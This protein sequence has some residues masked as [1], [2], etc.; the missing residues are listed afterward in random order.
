MEREILFRAKRLDNGQWV[1]GNVQ[2]PNKE[3]LHVFNKWFMWDE[4]NIQRQV[5][6]GTVGQF[7]GMT[8]KHGKRIFEG[9]IIR[10]GEIPDKQSEKISSILF[11]HDIL[12]AI[13][14][15]IW[16]E[17]VGNIYDNPELS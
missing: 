4:K 6:S 17:I 5:D 15:N 14:R 2:V 12:Y 1:E 10:I 11:M 16:V 8:D 9:D 3:T 13:S 7:T